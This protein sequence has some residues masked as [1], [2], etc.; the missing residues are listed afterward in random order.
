MSQMNAIAK[1]S[2]DRALSVRLVGYAE[3]AGGRFG[4]PGVFTG[5]FDSVIVHYWS[6]MSFRVTFRPDST[7]R[8][9]VGINDDVTAD[10]AS[11]E[12]L[13]NANAIVNFFSQ[14]LEENSFS[15]INEDREPEERGREITQK[16]VEM[17]RQYL[18][19]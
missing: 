3:T 10:D 16:L 1:R 9:V 7:P 17:A 15:F 4:A 14:G 18:P 11:E 19:A 5:L 2:S 12:A 8:S 6:G 13:K